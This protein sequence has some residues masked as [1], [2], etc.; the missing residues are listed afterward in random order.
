MIACQKNIHN[1]LPPLRAIL[2][3]LGIFERCGEPFT[4]ASL[5]F[6][7]KLSKSIEKQ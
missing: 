3:Y 1:S 5:E 2:S 6:V 7:E 4:G